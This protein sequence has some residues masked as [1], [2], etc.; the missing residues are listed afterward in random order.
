[1][2]VRL[3]PTPKG[4][5]SRLAKDRLDMDKHSGFFIWSVKV[6]KKK[7]FT[8]WTYGVYSAKTLMKHEIS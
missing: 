8:A 2:R 4:S 5:T 6:I 3:E 1:L 7:S